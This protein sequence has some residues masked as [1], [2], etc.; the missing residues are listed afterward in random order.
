MRLNA[1]LLALAL[2]GIVAGAAL[3]GRWAV[4]CAIITDSVLLGVWALLR[5]VPEKA[6]RGDQLDL[7]RRRQAS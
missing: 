7:V 6:M 1:V 2:V 3:I 4:G 5:D